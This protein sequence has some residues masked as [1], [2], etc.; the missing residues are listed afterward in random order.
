MRKLHSAYLGLLFCYAVINAQTPFFIFNTIDQEDTCNQVSTNVK[1]IDNRY[2]A[3]GSFNSYNQYSAF[4]AKCIDEAGQVLW[5]HILEDGTMHRAIHLGNSLTKTLDNHLLV[6][7]EKGNT[8][9]ET[10]V[11]LIKFTFEG[12]PVWIRTY[13]ESSWNSY[14]QVMTLSNNEYLLVYISETEFGSQNPTY[15]NLLKVDSIGEPLWHQYMSPNA[16]PLYSEQTLDGGF[17]ISGYQYN[18]ATGYDM[19]VVKTDATGTV[20]WER[21][22]GTPAND[23][24]SRAVQRPDGLVILIGVIKGEVTTSKL[25]YAILN[26]ANG[27][28]L[29]SITHQKYDK[30]SPGSSPLLLSD[31]RLALATLSYGPPPTWEVAFTIFDNAGN[32][33]QETPIS[34]GLPGEDYIRDLEPTPDGGFILAGFNYTVPQSSWVVKLGPNGEYCGT[35]PCVDSLI[36]N[37]ISTPPHIEVAQNNPTTLFPNPAKGST[38]I[39][40]TLPAQLPFAVVEFYDLQG[41][42]VLY[43]VLP[44]GGSPLNQLPLNPLKGSC[45]QTV[46]LSG[47]AAGVYIWRLALPGGYEQYEASGKLVVE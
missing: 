25:Y 34:S 6:V 28:V 46:D 10:Q 31:D 21:T 43:Q 2:I 18:D 13:E 14:M 47:L 41:Q 30:Y 15:I 16:T 8:P 45:T 22:Y 37:T 38:T 7:G 11:I 1:H 3:V 5:T 35:A 39:T 12:F 20:E 32:I 26:P 27:D 23:G 17:L 40:Y 29:Y 33:I 24:G 4:F 42:K 19:Y 36:T 9:Y 44:A